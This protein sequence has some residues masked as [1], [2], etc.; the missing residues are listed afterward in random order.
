MVATL[1]AIW[2][3]WLGH[4]CWGECIAYR[5]RKRWNTHFYH[6][7]WHKW[8]GLQTFNICK[9]LKQVYFAAEEYFYQSTKARV[10]MREVTFKPLDPP[11][12]VHF[13]A[14]IKP[15][16]WTYLASGS[17]KKWQPLLLVLQFKKDIPL[18]DT[19]I[20]NAQC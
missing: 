8:R 3:L 6:F 11:N 15:G 13:V 14:S 16:F 17:L 2:P 12:A 4:Q 7:S 9:L 5:Y 19:S 1:N 20:S 10:L 18:S